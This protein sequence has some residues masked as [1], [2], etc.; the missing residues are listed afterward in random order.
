MD[1]KIRGTGVLAPHFSQFCIESAPF[2]QGHCKGIPAGGCE[3]I[4]CLQKRALEARVARK[5]K[6]HWSNEKRR[7]FGVEPPRK[8]LKT[9]PFTL[10]LNATSSLVLRQNFSRKVYKVSNS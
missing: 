6:G 3:P 4:F 2:W 5:E 7:R 9:T 10:V 1:I 8:V